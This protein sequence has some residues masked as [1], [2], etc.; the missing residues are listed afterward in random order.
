MLNIIDRWRLNR[1]RRKLEKATEGAWDPE[2]SRKLDAI[3]VL[4]GE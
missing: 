4:L 1:I 3:L 2:L